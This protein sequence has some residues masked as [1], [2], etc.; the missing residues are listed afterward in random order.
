M[1]RAASISSS[2]QHKRKSQQGKK[3]LQGKHFPLIFRS[4]IEIFHG[5]KYPRQF[6]HSVVGQLV[7]KVPLNPNSCNK[8]SSSGRSPESNESFKRA[9]SVFTYFHRHSVLESTLKVV[10]SDHPRENLAKVS[11][12]R[13][14]GSFP[15]FG[16]ILT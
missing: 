15:C 13:S 12:W 5:G 14:S 16:V 3:I 9:K 4:K 8:G 2:S 10:F 6:Y 11:S 1:L 7:V